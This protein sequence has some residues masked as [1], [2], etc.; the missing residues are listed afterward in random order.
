MLMDDNNKFDT[1]SWVLFAA[2]IA[3]I[4]VMVFWYASGIDIS[5]TDYQSAARLMTER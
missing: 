5:I 3:S 4:L 2:G 1:I